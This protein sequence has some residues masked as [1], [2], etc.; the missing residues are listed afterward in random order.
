MTDESHRT[1]PVYDK[2]DMPSPHPARV[3]A[4]NASGVATGGGEKNNAMPLKALGS[5]N[6][7]YSFSDQPQPGFLERF[8]SPFGLIAG[9]RGSLHIEAPEFTS[10]CPIT[11]QPDFATIVIDYVPNLWCVESKSL[12]LYLGSFRMVGEFH[13]ACINRI[14]TDLIELLDP[15]SMT[16]VGRFTPR[17]GIPFWPTVIYVR[18][19]QARQQ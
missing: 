6:A 16:V 17:G 9:A 10:L 11:G 7:G 18:P 19:K 1:D 3:V 12:K 4:L 5:G 15:L 14:S 8:V 13:E 2:P